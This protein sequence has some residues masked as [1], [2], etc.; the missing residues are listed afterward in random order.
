MKTLLLASMMLL[1]A[2]A[3]PQ[4]KTNEVP[5]GK[6]VKKIKIKHADPKLL[7]LLITGRL[8]IGS[9]PEILP[10]KG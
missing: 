1:T 10:P 6:V 3:F 9:P 8:P 7:Y 5:Q 4:E 2:V